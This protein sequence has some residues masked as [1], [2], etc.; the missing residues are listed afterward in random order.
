MRHYLKRIKW[1][2]EDRVDEHGDRVTSI[3]LPDRDGNIVNTYVGDFVSIRYTSSSVASNEVGV[4][5]GFTPQRTRVLVRDKR[6]YFVDTNLV[7][8]HAGLLVQRY[9]DEPPVI[10]EQIPVAAV[11]PE[12][13]PNQPQVITGN[14]VE[15][16][17]PANTTDRKDEIND[18]FD[19]LEN[20]M[21]SCM[22]ATVAM[23][24]HIERGRETFR[25]HR[26]ARNLES[27]VA[28]IRVESEKRWNSFSEFVA[29]VREE[30]QADIN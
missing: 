18:Y 8:W 21:E 15:D 29:T 17:E 6:R 5:E 27:H 1:K 12:G 10:E 24:I 7:F 13:E 14:V 30:M 4:V 26:Y 3:K 16:E 2:P 28:R 11:E 20:L 22:E 23:N 25:G 9:E 19:Q